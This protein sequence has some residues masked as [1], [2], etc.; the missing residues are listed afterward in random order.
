[1]AAV[2]LCSHTTS[3]RQVAKCQ[4]GTTLLGNVEH[5]SRIALVIWVEAIQWDILTRKMVSISTPKPAQSA[6][7]HNLPFLDILGCFFGPYLIL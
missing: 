1:M 7:M 3:V 2:L 6:I 4:G 5:S